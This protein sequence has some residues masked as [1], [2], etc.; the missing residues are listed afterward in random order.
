[1]TFWEKRRQK[2]FSEASAAIARESKEAVKQ[3]LDA[4]DEEAKNR[5]KQFG[6]WKNTFKKSM[7][8]IV[9]GILLA[10]VEYK[11][12]GGIYTA[13]SIALFTVLM[14]FYTKSLR[15]AR[16]KY[17][18]EISVD[19]GATEIIRYLIPEEIWNLMEWDHPLVPG[20]VRMNGSDVF[21]ATKTWKVDGT[22]LIYKV[23]LAWFHFN[24][25]EYARSKP[26]LVRALEFATK[27]AHENTE[28]EKL[29][30]IM[31]V[32]EGKRQTGERISA[33]SSAYRDDPLVVKTRI[34]ESK[35]RIATLIDQ[36]K[37][38]LFN[39]DEKEEKPNA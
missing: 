16:G 23:K 29:N 27:L 19:S 4:K 20:S 28:L 17:L 30:N 15:P 35:R 18:L 38:L 13:A 26:V 14:Y 5:I 10:I 21:L 9:I 2:K 8:Q 1:M 36:N 39:T 31:S 11:I 25:L 12:I 3:A 22:N 6:S 24:Q 37:D 7:P 34:D 33:I 32:L